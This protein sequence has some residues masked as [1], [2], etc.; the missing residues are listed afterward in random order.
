LALV[1]ALGWG[2]A[3]WRLRRPRL[4]ALAAGIGVLGGWWVTFGLLTATP[5]Q[6]PER[7]PLLALGLVLLAGLGGGVAARWRGAGPV[8]AALGAL[9]VGWWMAGAPRTGA[10]LQRA[11]P[12]LAGIAGAAF[13]LAL[14]MRGGAIAAVVAGALLAGLAAAAAPGPG[15]VLGAAV[16]GA[17]LGAIPRAGAGPL[18][19]LPVAGAV[20]ALGAMPVIARGAAADWA[21]ASASLL[22]VLF[23]PVVVRWLPPSLGLAGAAAISAAPAVAVSFFL[24]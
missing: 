12:V 17:A 24:R 3:A 4:A 8:L 9:A 7:L 14:R 21:A 1:L 23:A 10:D 20:A 16:L 19:A 6:L 22:A 2:V 15:M 5:R 18:A 11:A 13:L